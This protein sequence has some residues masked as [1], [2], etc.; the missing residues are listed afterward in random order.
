GRTGRNRRRRAREQ[1]WIAPMNTK[2]V[3]PFSL[4][5]PACG[6]EPRGWRQEPMT[7][8]SRSPPRIL[9][10]PP[11][12]LRAVLAR[13]LFDVLESLT[14]RLTGAFCRPPASGDM[15]SLSVDPPWGLRDAPE[16]LAGT[17]D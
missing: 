2:P 7:V 16:G 5:S 17:G 6:G 10:L 13:P 1:P 4:P 14:R 15:K 11:A 3:V 9:C 8:I 12:V